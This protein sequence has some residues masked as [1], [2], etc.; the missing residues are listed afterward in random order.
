M[1]VSIPLSMSG[2]QTGFTPT[3][4]ALLAKKPLDV[5]VIISEDGNPSLTFMLDKCLMA[6]YDQHV[7]PLKAAQLFGVVVAGQDALVELSAT[8]MAVR[9]RKSVV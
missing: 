9:D 8:S 1:Y 7:K 3:K 2:F 4:G 6:K 5:G